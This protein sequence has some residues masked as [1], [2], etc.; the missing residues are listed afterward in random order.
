MSCR[1]R[2][3]AFCLLMSCGALTVT[4]SA[5]HFKQVT[6]TLTQVA[7]GR[8]EVFG[9]NASN[10]VYRYSASTK[11]FGLVTGTLIQVAVGGGT[12]SQKD[13]IWGI[14][15]SEQIYHFNFGTKAFVQVAGTF[16]QIAVGEGD[17]DTCHPY[18]V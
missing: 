7:V 1:G 15:P 14:R 6:G 4:A 5:Q 10:Q 12:L 9:V 2:L 11:S 17:E 13:E 3:W 8:N 18:E 16:F